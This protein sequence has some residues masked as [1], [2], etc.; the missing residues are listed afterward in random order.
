MEFEDFTPRFGKWYARGGLAACL[1]GIRSDES[2]NRWR[3][4]SATSRKTR[5]VDGAGHAWPWSTWLGEGLYNAYP[6]YDWRTE[7]VWRYHAHTGQPYNPLYD[8]MYGAGLSIHQMRIC[9]PYGDDQRRGLWLYHIIEPETWGRVVSRVQGANQGA[10]YVQETG[11]IMG[12]R[13]I[14]KPTGHTWESFA[15]LL[16]ATLPAPTQRHYAD[17]IAVFCAWWATRGY[18]TIPDEAPHDEEAARKTPSWR[19]ICKALLRNDYWCKGLSFSQHVTPA[20]EKY[21]KLIKQRRST[22]WQAL[23]PTW[24]P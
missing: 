19:R 23:L 20:W 13:R 11:N 14:D 15:R 16:L 18:T 7:D 9:Q 5:Y 22:R 12:N 8:R 3:T 17:K 6:I 4:I 2:L 10:L 24:L 1:V 21:R